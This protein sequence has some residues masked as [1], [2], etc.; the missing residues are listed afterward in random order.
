MLWAHS[1]NGAG[2]QD[3]SIVID[4]SEGWELWIRWKNVRSNTMST[5]LIY[6]ESSERLETLLLLVP[7]AINEWH[8]SWS[9]AQQWVCLYAYDARVGPTS[10]CVYTCVC[11]HPKRVCRFCEGGQWIAE[12]KVTLFIFWEPFHLGSISKEK[13]KLIDKSWL[14]WCHIKEREKLVIK[15]NS[16]C[17]NI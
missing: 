3:F 4:R 12:Q 14:F 15:E 11:M 1:P 16:G 17:D 10:V 2:F 8:M 13:T 9:L 5:A 7:P 6:L